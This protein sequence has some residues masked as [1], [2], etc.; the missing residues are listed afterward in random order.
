MYS[1]TPSSIDDNLDLQPDLLFT[2]DSDPDLLFTEA[3]D[4]NSL[5]PYKY[6]TPDIMNL[7]T[8]ADSSRSV[9]SSLQFTSKELLPFNSPPPPSASS[10]T[11]DP[12]LSS[13]VDELMS[14]ISRRGSSDVRPFPDPRALKRQHT[15]TSTQDTPKRNS[16][17]SRDPRRRTSKR[18]PHNL[19]E[20]KYRNTLNAELERL[21]C[22]IPHIAGLG[23]GADDGSNNSSKPSKANILASAVAYIRSMEMEYDR[24]N[25]KQEELQE[26]LSLALRRERL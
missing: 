26:L 7:F 12:R 8:T 4:P 2:E 13:Y 10:E 3:S 17:P 21:R 5:F 16:F 11:D 22:A 9:F 1:S 25:K 20:R 19:V 15:E 23:G 24:L 18:V 6:T 14:P